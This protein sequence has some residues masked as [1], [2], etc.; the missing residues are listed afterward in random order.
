MDQISHLLR[1]ARDLRIQVC[2]AIFVTSLSKSR[3]R[4][5]AWELLWVGFRESKSTG[6]TGGIS[7]LS[8]RAWR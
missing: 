1:F 4:D 7:V 6:N 2:L 8:V 5:G 3:A